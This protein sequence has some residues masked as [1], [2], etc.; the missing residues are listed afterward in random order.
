M[1]QKYQVIGANII[2]YIGDVVSGHNCDFTTTK[3]PLT[4]YEILL[5]DERAKYHKLTLLEEYGECGS[6]WTTAKYGIM[7]VE[8]ISK[9]FPFNL[10]PKEE[11]FIECD[12]M[13]DTVYTDVFDVSLFGFDEY[14]PDG[15]VVF[16]ETLFVPI[17]GLKSLD[18]IKRYVHIFKGNSGLGKSYLA[19]LIKNKTVYETDSNM[20]LPEIIHDDIIVIGNK[21]NFTVDDVKKRINK[22][23]PVKIIIVDF[24]LD[25]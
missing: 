16:D 2:K 8:N 9:P 24:S 7:N 17:R 23:V 25:E 21:Y 6:G 1:K 12:L 5:K 20:E 15:F 22:S 10:K 18:D 19:Q 13:S 11:L 4:K 3:E 14:Y